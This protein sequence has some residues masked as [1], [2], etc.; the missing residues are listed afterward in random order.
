MAL[1]LPMRRLPTPQKVYN[2]DGSL[3]QKGDIRFY[4]D[5]ELQTGEKRTNM[6]FFATELGPHQLILGYPWFAT[7]QPQID[8]AKGW[9]DYTQLPVVLQSPNVYLAK[10]LRRTTT[11]Q[12]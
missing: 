10:F 5:L 9:I 11:G 3:N 6:R 4:T 1:R 7:I 12:Q 8:W 2:V